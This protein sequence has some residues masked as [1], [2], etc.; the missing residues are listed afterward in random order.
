M[1]PF[2]KSRFVLGTARYPAPSQLVAA[3]ERSKVNVVTV[4]LRR[5][6]K[7][8]GFWKILREL[9][10][11]FLPN[12]AACHSVEEAVCTAEMAREIFETNWIKLEVIGD[13]YTL[14]PHPI[15]LVKACEELAKRGF[16]VFPYCTAD[17]VIAQALLDAGAKAL[18]PWGAPIGSG[19]GL[20]DPYA[21]KLLR[22]RFPDTTLIVDAGLG[23]PSQA[24]RVMEM[25]YDGV[26]LN[27]AVAL[28]DDPPSMAE[29]F[30][31]AINAGRQAYEAGLMAPREMAEA[32]TP[33]FGTPSWNN[34][35]TQEAKNPF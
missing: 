14:Q 16:E 21:L 20:M 25:G 33:S 23:A 10:I 2:G 30:A 13:D 8:E 22:K 17:L 28:A 5:E 4:S 1:W 19:R 15:E 12:T 26:L 29:A 18:M 32:S 9:P 24:A 27:T 3:I 11:R 31:S 35:P 7:G 6:V 34:F